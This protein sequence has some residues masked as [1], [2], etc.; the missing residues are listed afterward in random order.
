M[1]LPLYIS[2]R[3]AVKSKRQDFLAI[4]DPT[5]DLNENTLKRFRADPGLI[6]QA[7]E[8]LKVAG[9]MVSDI[10]Q[11]TIGISGESKLFKR[12]FRAI[13]IASERGISAEGQEPFGIIDISQSEFKDL[14][15]GIALNQPVRF[16]GEYDPPASTNKSIAPP[17]LPRYLEMPEQPTKGNNIKIAVIDSGFYPHPFLKEKYLDSDS[18]NKVKVQVTDPKSLNQK[19][20]AIESD[21]NMIT[22][23]KKQLQEELNSYIEGY[24]ILEEAAK[25]QQLTQETVEKLLKKYNHL[26]NH[27]ENTNNPKHEECKLAYEAELATI[28]KELNSYKEWYLGIKLILNEEI[29][30]EEHGTHVMSNFLPLTS[31]IEYYMIKTSVLDDSIQV[32]KAALEHKP[33]IISCSFGMHILRTETKIP[34][35]SRDYIRVILRSQ[36]YLLVRKKTGWGL[37]KKRSPRSRDFVKHP[38]IILYSAGNDGKSKI[39]GNIDKQDVS[40]EAQLSQV[41]SVGGAFISG[42]N[43]Q[44]YVSREKQ[45]I[46]FSG[47]S[48]G[49]KS[50]LSINAQKLIPDICGICGVDGPSESYM[51]VPNDDEENG[52][53]K[54]WI[55]AKGTSLATP[56]VAGIVSLILQVYPTADTA[57]VKRI[58]QLSADEVKGGDSAQGEDMAELKFKVKNYDG[59][60]VD[61]AVGLVNAQK[62]LEVAKVANAQ[63]TKKQSQ[64]V[65]SNI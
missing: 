61:K 44:K 3:A 5:A 62:A 24:Q 42:Y 22:S 51:W 30:I 59:K 64:N 12:H 15:S 2:A 16:M 27:F 63:E 10:S 39:G 53:P 38:P 33:Q 13:I 21:W 35:N 6:K 11:T 23:E 50:N 52:E 60:E 17:D 9:F 25:Q 34:E 28:D 19:L 40:I 54:K 14:L 45:R 41:I 4:F 20:A 7:V 36:N 37:R 32:F 46:Q 43:P 48:H 49:Y 47:F 26:N 1:E 65:N 58:L 56:H 29:D 8:Q 31:H 57:A 18:Q 55:P